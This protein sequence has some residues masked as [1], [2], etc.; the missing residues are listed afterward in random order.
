[1]NGGNVVRVKRAFAKFAR[2]LIVVLCCLFVLM[3]ATPSVAADVPDGSELFLRSGEFIL[4]QE[5]FFGRWRMTIDFGLELE[6]FEAGMDISF[7]YKEGDYRYEMN[8]FGIDTTDIADFMLPSTAPAC[9]VVIGRADEDVFY[10][11]LPDGGW[12]VLPAQDDMTSES[13]LNSF[14]APSPEASGLIITGVEA[15]EWQGSNAWRVDGIVPL[16]EEVMF[17]D[18]THLSVTFS[19]WF[20]EK[21]SLMLGTVNTFRLPS[22]GD[23]PPFS[24]A[25]HFNLIEYDFHPDMADDELFAP[26]VGLRG[27]G[28]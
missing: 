21:T 17:P 22:H 11:Q 20:D 25:I 19:Y 9:F 13:F 15:D 10:C 28:L 27:A 12:Q 8:V 14:L 2:R 24:F 3:A 16:P 6:M 18:N 1:M 26:P 7:W 4:A 23:V 5:R